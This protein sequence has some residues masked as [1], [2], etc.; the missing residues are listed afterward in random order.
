MALYHNHY[1][2][3]EL[4]LGAAE[5]EVRRAFKKMREIYAH[6]SLAVYS[7]YSPREIDDLQKKFEEAYT[8]L[9]DPEKREKYHR[10]FFPDYVP[11]PVHGMQDGSEYDKDNKAEDAPEES[12]IAEGEEPPEPFEIDDNTEFTGELLR[13]YRR[14]KNVDLR[15]I[16]DHTKVSMMYLRYIEQ[17]KYNLLPATVYVRGFIIEYAKYLKLDPQQVSQSFLEKYHAARKED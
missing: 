17:D 6:D 8:V 16:A 4:E 11:P 14:H 12:T 2:F 1:Q 13:R 9:I 15:D 5:E 3:M 7:V 10:E